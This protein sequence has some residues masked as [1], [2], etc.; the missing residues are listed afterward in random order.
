MGLGEISGGRNCGVPEVSPR[1]YQVEII[2]KALKRPQGYGLFME[3][4]TGKTATSLFCVR[5]WPEGKVLVVCPKKALSVWEEWIPKMGM[6]RECFEVL[7]FEQFVIQF[8]QLEKIKFIG[9]IVDESHRIKSRSGL[10]AKSLHK[11]SRKIPNKLILTGTYWDSGY[12]DLFSQLKVID[13]DRFDDWK[14]F[15]SRYLVLER[16]PLPDYRSWNVKD[17]R[18]GQFFE[19]VVGYKNKDELENILMEITSRVERSQVSKVKTLIRKKLHKIPMSELTQKHYRELEQSLITEYKGRET[20]APLILTLAVRLQQLSGGFLTSDDK[21]VQ[22]V[23]VEKL[24]ALKSLLPAC[25]PAVVVARFHAEIS[26]IRG[27]C[28]DLGLT[29]S[30]I[31]GKSEYNPQARPDVTILQ[32]QSGLAIDLSYSKHMI[33]FS[34]DYSFINWSQFKDRIVQVDTPEIFYHYLIL[35]NSIDELVYQAVVEKRKLT[36]LLNQKYLKRPFT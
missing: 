29:Y 36:D 23:G 5:E 34:Q 15:A 18:P 27:I 21:H 35:Q 6:D 33:I 22:G 17:L 10:W 3:Q 31:H 8:H 30:E 24:E 16:I 28:Q 4:R 25:L 32:P 20:T 11:I 2:Q 1:D 7:N 19:K 12:E 13:R 14:S 26:A 9:L